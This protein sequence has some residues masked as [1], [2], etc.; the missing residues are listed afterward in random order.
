MRLGYHS[1]GGLL[2]PISR[3]KERWARLAM[4]Q[5]KQ[6]GHRFIQGI[7][8]GIEF[9]GRVGAF[10]GM[11]GVGLRRQQLVGAGD[12]RGG[13]GLLRAASEGRGDV[14]HLAYQ[15]GGDKSNHSHGY[16]ES[17]RPIA[18]ATNCRRP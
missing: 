1:A 7:G 18:P 17:P 5:S 4:D 3:G 6:V 2:W 9:F 10:L 14:W 8:L 11:G 15:P 16:K 13:G 12:F